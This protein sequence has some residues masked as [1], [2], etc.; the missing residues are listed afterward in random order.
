M[1]FGKN[2]ET[3]KA[4]FGEILRNI[5]AKDREFVSYIKRCVYIE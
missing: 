1:A 2:Y 3:F 4:E 5:Q